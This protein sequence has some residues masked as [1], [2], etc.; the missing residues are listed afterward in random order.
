MPKSRWNTITVSP[1]NGGALMTRP[2][3]QRAGIANYTRKLDFR[4]DLDQ[5]MR[6]EG[7]DYF[8]GNESKP[9]GGQ[10]FPGA[11]YSGSVTGTQADG[12][13][14]ITA[15]NPFFTNAMIGGIV[16]YSNGFTATLNSINSTTEAILSA[17]PTEDL[18]ALA[19]W[20]FVPTVEPITL[21][22][23]SR[24]PNGKVNI[25]VG[26][27]TRLWR[28]FSLEDGRY[29]LGLNDGPGGTYQIYV[30]GDSNGPYFEDFAGD[31]QLIGKG[32][33]PMAYGGLKVFTSG[34]V[35]AAQA[36]N[37]ATVTASAPYFSLDMV[38]KQIRFNG[39]HKA[40]ITAFVSANQV[41]VDEKPPL[42]ITAQA[43]WILTGAHRWEAVDINGYTIFNNGADLPQVFRLEWDAVRPLYELREQGVARVGTIANFFGILMLADITDIFDTKIADNFAMLDS[44]AITATQ[45][46]ATFSG[47]VTAFMSS[48][49][50]T[51]QTT[52]AA[53]FFNG[54]MV[55]KRIRFSNGFESE[56]ISFTSPSEV[57][58]FDI[59]ATAFAGLPF[60]IITVP[61]STEV[62]TSAP[63]FTEDMVGLHIVWDNGAERRI[64]EFVST[65][66]IITDLDLA[67]ASGEFKIENRFAYDVYTESYVNRRQFR[68]LW[69]LPDEPTRFGPAIPAAINS[70]ER[71]VRLSYPVKSFEIG[72]SV[73][74]VGAGAAGGLFT[75]E[76]IFIDPVGSVLT[77]K[78]TAQT[79]VLAQ[80]ET[81]IPPASLPDL[82]GSMTSGQAKL[83]LDI[84]PPKDAFKAGEQVT[85]GG[86]GSSGNDLTATIQSVADEGLTIVLDTPA[87]ATV[88]KAEVKLVLQEGVVFRSDTPGSILGYA[89]LQDDGS[90]ILR[91]AQLGKTLVIFKDTSFFLAAYTGIPEAPFAFDE[92]ISSPNDQTLHYRWALCCVNGDF[93]V[94]PGRNGF[95]RFDLTGRYPQFLQE[96]DL[97]QNVFFDKARIE[98]TEEIFVAENGPTQEKMWV[99]PITGDYESY[100]DPAYEY[101]DDTLDRALIWDF[102]YGTFRTTSARITAASTVKRPESALS[103]GE[104]ED[105]FV[106]GTRH[107]TVLLY[108]KV[109]RPLAYWGDKMSIWYRRESYPYS[110]VKSD[111]EC[112]LQWGTADLGAP[113][114][115]KDLH[116]ILFLLGSQMVGL[117]MPTM[118]YEL[119]TARNASET[120][121]LALNF[122]IVLPDTENL[123]PLFFRQNY[124]QSKLLISGLDRQCRLASV[125]WKFGVIGSHSAIRKPS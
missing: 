54:G 6:A 83:T 115:E 22:H 15:S 52:A 123:I 43:F 36:V 114:E 68:L 76:I 25:V 69:S 41:Q 31:W 105:W 53:A 97:V 65:T 109:E 10:P 4:R 56:I 90:G 75:S 86:A 118:V 93:F 70:D 39:G 16:L 119:R 27:P 99:F 125:I 80:V 12:S 2:S 111:Y 100:Y 18:V 32:F 34:N 61:T 72:H 42:A 24:R 30:D 33:V 44:A 40:R 55:G 124:F 101:E 51:V 63:F 98:L 38:G 14:T 57:E 122:Q 11:I 91:M 71:T 117:A 92:P 121:S 112:M 107:Q 106:M 74:I 29:V 19:F 120:L 79:S 89:D 5:E 50:T 96:F 1:A 47:L 3:G 13:T 66:K 85:V 77:L 113:N 9:I 60:W 108:G 67:V 8:Y 21:V 82:T 87:S 26:T 58:V 37:S 81:P 88:V 23:L 62:T 46:G 73:S 84:A 116:D 45:T 59:E 78:E 64:N 95:Y 49:D 17:A 103:V 94:Y 28:F 102:R 20:V 35:T 7:H 110:T 104:T 48:G